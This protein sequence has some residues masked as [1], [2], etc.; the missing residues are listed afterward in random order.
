MAPAA[1]RERPGAV[2]PPPEPPLSGEEILAIAEHEV[3]NL[4]AVI[5]GLAGRLDRRWDQLSDPERRQLAGRIAAQAVQ[6]S[7]LVANLRVLATNTRDE[8][9]GGQVRLDPDPAAALVTLV[10]DA[11]ALVPDHEV[12]ADIAADLPPL[13]LDAARL[14]QVVLN[15][16]INAA[17]FSPLRSV[18]TV[19]ARLDGG[20]L[21]LYVDDAGPGI[22]PDQR[23]AV[24]DKSFQ[25]DPDRPGSGLGL[26]ISRRLVEAMGGS[27]AI[28]EAPAG[29]CR[30]AIELPTR[31]DAR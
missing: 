31:R 7:S 4:T 6:L 26:F 14:H 29:G 27:I 28:E 23:T 24:F 15:L 19:G 18:I 3:G 22:A 12:V 2:A 30:V 11:R 1:A 25:V 17:K 5:G 16:V 8:H 21:R 10:D 9:A 13:P 20:A